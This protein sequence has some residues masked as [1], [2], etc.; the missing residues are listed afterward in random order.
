MAVPVP[1]H[2]PDPH[3]GARQDGTAASGAVSTTL[4]TGVIT[5]EA[6]TTAAGAD[7]TLT[8]TN[9]NFKTTSLVLANVG[10]GTSTT[11]VP[12]MSSVTPGAGTCVIVVQNIHATAALNGTLKIGFVI[13]SS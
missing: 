1:S 13:I 9:Q 7:Y 5:S 10:N 8:I 11:G 4:P 6:L 12:D 3:L 2:N